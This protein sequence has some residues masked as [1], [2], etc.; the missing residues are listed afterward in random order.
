[1]TSHRET[2]VIVTTSPLSR[3]QT[4]LESL[5]KQHSPWVE[6]GTKLPIRPGIHHSEENTTLGKC[7]PAR[8]D[9]QLPTQFNVNRHTAQPRYSNKNRGWVGIW[10]GYAVIGA[11]ECPQASLK[12]LLPP[13]LDRFSFSSSCIP[14][15]PTY[16]ETTQKPHLFT[17]QTPSTTKLFTMASSVSHIPMP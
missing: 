7:V 12:Y 4:Y 14:Y 9:P 15:T 3:K 5:R 1:M 11:S 16:S 8:H 10:N 13:L 17:Y 2:S 6:N